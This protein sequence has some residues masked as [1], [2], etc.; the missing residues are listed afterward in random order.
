MDISNKFS[1]VDFLAYLFPGI[2]GALGL[3]FLLLLTPLSSSLMSI[4]I[5]LATGVL[6]LAFSYVLGVVFSGFAEIIVRQRI[7]RKSF[8]WVKKTL[9]VPG[10]K[11]EI[12]SAFCATFGDGEDYEI[13]RSASRFYLCRS[14]VLEFMPGVAPRIRRQISLR[15]LRMNLIPAVT[16]WA[17]AGV[18]W[19]IKVI[20]DKMPTWGYGLIAG[21]VGLWV[22]V[23]WAIVNRMNSNE[24][25]E[26]REVFTAFLAGYKKGL[27]KEKKDLESE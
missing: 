9:Q 7:R 18:G 3:Y 14:M 24:K 5:D 22:L 12:R 15:Q 6:L 4:P 21:S 20:G 10:F 26:V 8:V 19:G 11:E 1:L 25:R 16:L 27:F 2:M 23:V 17:V 13:D